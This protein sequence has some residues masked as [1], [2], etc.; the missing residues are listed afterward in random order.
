MK[1]YPTIARV[2]YL[3]TALL[4]LLG[5]IIMTVGLYRVYLSF[6]TAAWP[7]TEA[8]IIESRVVPVPVKNGYRYRPVIKYRYTV[9]GVEY[10]GALIRFNN[11]DHDNEQEAAQV[12]AGFPIGRKV[13]LSFQGDN[14]KISVL[15]PGLHQSDWLTASIGFALIGVCLV[16]RFARQRWL[17]G[18]SV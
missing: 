4:S 7:T 10:T 11:F 15:E 18:Q 9:N 14:P 13:A 3:L 12:V 8:Q 5:L 16:L 17:L 6:R 2:V 1:S